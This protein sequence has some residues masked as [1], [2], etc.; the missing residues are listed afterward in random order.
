M[1][2]FAPASPELKI[3]DDCWLDVLSVYL[4]IKVFVA[5]RC[6][7][8]LMFAIGNIFCS[9]SVVSIFLYATTVPT[10]VRCGCHKLVSCPAFWGHCAMLV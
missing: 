3:I 4:F 5:N 8:L 10:S 1:S 6:V 9:S 7:T 2:P